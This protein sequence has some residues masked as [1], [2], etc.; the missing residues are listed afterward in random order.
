[1]YVGVS[2]P[3]GIDSI[4]LWRIKRLLLFRNFQAHAM[5]F[6][7]LG[8]G[9]IGCH[10]AFELG[11]RNAVTLLLR[12]QVHVKDFVAR[13]STIKYR[14]RQRDPVE[15]GSF[16]ALNVKDSQAISN[17]TIEALIVATKSQHAVDAVHAVK[18]MLNQDSTV[19]LFQ[20]GMG[21]AEELLSKV[22][23]STKDAP[24]IIAGVNRHA[25]ERLGP[26]HIKHNSGWND[27][28]GLNL[29]AL[30]HSRADKVRP[31]FKAFEECPDFRTTVLEWPELLKRML[32]KLV[33]NA[34]INPVAALLDV[35][36]GKL[37]ENAG[38]MELLEGL[39]KEAAETL[40][41]LQ[42]TGEELLHEVVKTA[43]IS[44]PNNCTTVQDLRAKRK[45]EID[46]INGYLVRLAKE[47][48]VQVP[49]NETL[50]RL[51]HAKEA[52]IGAK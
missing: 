17:R 2:H 43:E 3:V 25:I 51:I 5:H 30:P 49:I 48:G 32:R 13:Q 11:R 44:S 14:R 36:N 47:R 20:N 38:S 42:A 39:T 37:L 23:T 40:T 6:H 24:S 9:A 46:F 35:A 7:I 28:N 16:D 45:T 10:L 21:V 33:V 19:L 41:E 22:W 27:P 8:T 15:L 1:M 31:I 26:F 4:Y 29:G 34:T 52:V 50:I 12:S 18:P